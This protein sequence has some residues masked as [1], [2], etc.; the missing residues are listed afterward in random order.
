MRRW[1][2]DVL[3]ITRMS[4]CRRPAPPAAGGKHGIRRIA[5]RV[6][7]ALLY[8]RRQPFHAK[9]SRN[10]GSARYQHQFWQAVSSAVIWY[11]WPFM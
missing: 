10:S 7:F 5:N 6:S 9:A 11:R 8:K 2:P 4:I 3:A 1:I